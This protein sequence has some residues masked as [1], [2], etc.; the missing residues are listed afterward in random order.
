[1]LTDREYYS[2]HT[3]FDEI[4]CMYKVHE[5]NLHVFH[6]PVDG[7]VREE[8]FYSGAGSCEAIKLNI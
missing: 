3:N 7:P 2:V 6:S 5:N 8:E 1:M 4:L